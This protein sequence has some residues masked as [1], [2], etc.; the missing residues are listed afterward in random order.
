MVD[1]LVPGSRYRLPQPVLVPLFLALIY[2]WFYGFA[3]RKLVTCRNWDIHSSP[4]TIEVAVLYMLRT[5][6][7]LPI[8]ITIYRMLPS[9]HALA[10][11][12]GPPS[13]D[14]RLIHPMSYIG[15]MRCPQGSHISRDTIRIVDIIH[16]NVFT[17]HTRHFMSDAAWMISVS[18]NQI[19]NT[20]SFLYEYI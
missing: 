18:H 20:L 6:Y 17:H 16:K 4:V 5:I 1:H 13:H 3:V 19:T 10:T 11:G 14:R 12:S 15:N 7:S 9:K 8:Q 2:N